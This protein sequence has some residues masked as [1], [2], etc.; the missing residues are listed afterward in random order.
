MG[1]HPQAYMY[2]DVPGQTSLSAILVNF[3]LSIGQCVGNDRN[4]KENKKI[5]SYNTN[6]W[7]SVQ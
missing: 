7:N 6:L 1:P 2:T 3:D 5:D 4:L